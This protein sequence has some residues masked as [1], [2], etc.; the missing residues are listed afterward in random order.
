M[1]QRRP[2]VIG[3]GAMPFGSGALVGL[4]LAHPAA[5]HTITN[6]DSCKRLPGLRQQPFSSPIQRPPAFHCSG[7]MASAQ[8]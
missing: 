5:G 6:F 1:Q 3:P 4:E 8:S 2:G 7:T